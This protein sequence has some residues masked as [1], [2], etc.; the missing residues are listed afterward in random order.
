MGGE[1]TRTWKYFYLFFAIL[2][3]FPVFGCSTLEKIRI[4]IS[5]QEE[6]YQSLLQGQKLLAEGDYE[7]ALWEN[8]KVI[9][10]SP[11]RPPEDRALFNIGRIHAHPGN[12]KKDY[13]KSVTYFKKV[14]EGYPINPLAEEAK[15][16]IA[17]AQEHDKLTQ[18]IIKLSQRRVEQPKKESE[19]VRALQGQKLLAQG[20]YEGALRENQQVFSSSPPSRQVDEALFNIGL[21]YAHPGNPK[22]DYGKAVAFCQKLIKEYPQSP[23]VEE[24][25]TLIGMIQENDKLNRT[26]ERLNLTIEESKKTVERLNQVIE[27]SKKVD[28]QIEE[29]KREKM[30]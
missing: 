14:V 6:A 26:V 30:K 23:L 2:I 8:E 27:E 25:K 18:V 16:W 11:S 7:G 4:K 28:I 21:I 29:K 10:L 20:D 15:I 13:S 17:M 24:A 9:S 1:Q 12:P 5:G 22:K 3:F 19:S